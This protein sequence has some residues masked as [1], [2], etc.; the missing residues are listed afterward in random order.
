MTVPL[1]LVS[2]GHYL[3]SFPAEH[4]GTCVEVRLG[5]GVF[6]LDEAQ[7]AVW[8]APDD[9][10]HDPSVVESV[11]ALGLSVV[12]AE[13][14]ETAFARAYRLVPLMLGLGA[15]ADDDSRRDLGIP[16]RPLVTVDRLSYELWAVAGARRSL[17]QACES[18][19]DA[20][21]EADGASAGWASAHDVLVELLSR[22]GELTRAGAACLDLALPGQSPR[23]W[24]MSHG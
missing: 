3:G 20:R 8:F 11:R 21:S 9:A 23:R 10:G 16:G 7:A 5:A 17:W 14:G 13:R 6:T 15:N 18:F 22:L 24:E 19:A 4:G 2:V 1:G 12:L